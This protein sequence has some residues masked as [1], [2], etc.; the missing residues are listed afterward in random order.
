MEKDEKEYIEKIRKRGKVAESVSAAVFA[1]G[2]AIVLAALFIGALQN[3][4][5][6]DKDH[7][8][9]P[10]IPYSQLDNAT[11]TWTAEEIQD[12][13]D[14]TLIGVLIGGAVF[15]IGYMGM[16]VCRYI[17]P[18]RREYH[19]ESC[20]FAQVYKTKDDIPDSYTACPECGEKL[21]WLYD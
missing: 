4:P 20:N 5:I 16:I 3:G 6:A 14:K 7:L 18:G 12:A 21:K 13:A 15:A 10:D 9:D 2:A 8:T 1:V 19:R 11:Y 17:S